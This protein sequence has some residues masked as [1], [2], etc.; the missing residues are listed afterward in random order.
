VIASIAF[1]AALSGSADPVTTYRSAGEFAEAV[2]AATA[3]YHD[4]SVA[5]A[6]GYRLIGRDFPGMG[7][8]W[9]NIGLVFD[10]RHE[11]TR[12][13]FLSY[14]TVQGEPRL[15]GVAYAVPLLPGESPPRWPWGE[16]S[17]HDHSRSVDEETVLP[18]R[19]DGGHHAHA[20]HAGD[21][22]GAEP[23][24][25]M[26]HAW[27]WLPNPDGDFVSDNWALPYVRLG[28]TPPT[29]ASDAS[30]R[31]LALVSGGAEYAMDVLSNAP[32]SE[33]KRLRRAIESARRSVET[34]LRRRQGTELAQPQ[35]RALEAVWERLWK[36][37][38]RRLG[39]SARERLAF[40]R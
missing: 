10:G 23:R 29:G 7:E 32:P 30:A 1:A 37:I 16:V 3:Q 26:A 25:A 31:A 5:I 11:P 22:A 40:L 12:P 17:W 20:G 33:Q 21:P 9:I 2:R 34:V 6:D 19:M 14:V 28:L 39:P 4:R 24:L 15:V 13:E 38:D 18:H 8:H 27:V 35:V 36:D